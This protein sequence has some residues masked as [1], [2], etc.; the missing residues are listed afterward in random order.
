MYLQRT[1]VQLWG[2]NAEADNSRKENT[3]SMMKT[4]RP[5]K[6]RMR[7]ATDMLVGP[8]LWDASPAILMIAQLS[9]LSG[10]IA[11]KFNIA[12][13]L[14]LVEDKQGPTPDRLRCKDGLL[15]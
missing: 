5:L 9:V 4:S 8:G 1:Q 14:V 3:Y 12:F 10:K 11:R 7:W 6:C 2:G 13:I 15:C